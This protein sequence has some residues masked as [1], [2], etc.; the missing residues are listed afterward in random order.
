MDAR[1]AL[2]WLREGLQFP[3]GLAKDNL[4]FLSEGYPH[5]HTPDERFYRAHERVKTYEEILSRIDA[6][7]DRLAGRGPDLDSQLAKMK[8]DPLPEFPDPDQWIE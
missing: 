3:Y 6:M 8:L 4:H 2:E 7:L 1:Q 5:N